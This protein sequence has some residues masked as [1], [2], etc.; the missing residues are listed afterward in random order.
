MIPNESESKILAVDASVIAGFLIFLT[1]GASDFFEGKIIQQVEILTA[2]IVFP[3]A[4]A[5]I[6]TLMKGN[7]EEYGIKFMIA[8]FIYLM[9]SV[10]LIAFIQ[11]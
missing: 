3:F 4:I 6:R 5:A 8:G 9:T 7:V 2:S 1:I 11:K 10:I